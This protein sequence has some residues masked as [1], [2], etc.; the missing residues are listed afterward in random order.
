M[1]Y[2]DLLTYLQGLEQYVHQFRMM[3]MDDMGKEF[4]LAEMNV[5]DQRH[6]VRM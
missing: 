6:L 1:G 2:I 4:H 3:F 5:F